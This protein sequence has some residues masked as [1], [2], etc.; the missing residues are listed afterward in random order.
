M[1]YV[2]DL[3]GTLCT[4]EG[5]NY[6]D[7]RPILERIARVRELYDAGCLIVIQTGRHRSHEELTRRQLVEWEIPWHTFSIGA[8]VPGRL[9]VDDRAVNAADFFGAKN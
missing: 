6:A 2:F 5:G 4:D 8:K 3:D 9:Y 7:A 1:T